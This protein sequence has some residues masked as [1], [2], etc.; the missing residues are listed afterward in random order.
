MKSNLSQIYPI[1]FL[2]LSKKIVLVKIYLPIFF[3]VCTDLHTSKFDAI[4]AITRF[5]LGCKL[6]ANLFFH[7]VDPLG[8]CW[9]AKD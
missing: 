5:A 1:P 6:S 4:A 9:V 2:S 7:P 3:Q 8:L